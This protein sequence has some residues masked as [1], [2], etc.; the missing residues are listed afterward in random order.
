MK[1]G[2]VSAGPTTV[3]FFRT[4]GERL[5]LQLPGSSQVSPLALPL[6]LKEA[7]E[8]SRMLGTPGRLVFRRSQDL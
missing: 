8:R 2:E 6:V 4:E 3:F 1:K 7:G 5:G